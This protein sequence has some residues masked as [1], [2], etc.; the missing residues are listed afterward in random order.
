M[1]THMSNFQKF[2]PMIL[3]C[4]VIKIGGLFMFIKSHTI[5]IILSKSY[6]LTKVQYLEHY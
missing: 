4:V 1:C 5:I 6:S 3:S 2:G